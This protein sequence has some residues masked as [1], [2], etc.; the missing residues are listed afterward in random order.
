[1]PEVVS[2]LGFQNETYFN[3]HG[4]KL[5]NKSLKALM[6]SSFN[7]LH[8]FLKKY[9]Y[10]MIFEKLDAQQKILKTIFSF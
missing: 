3:M 10:H 9:N 8:D 6:R 2:R 5:E 1:M 4:T 7:L